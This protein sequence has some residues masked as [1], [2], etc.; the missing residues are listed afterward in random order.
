MAKIFVKV[1]VVMKKSE[2]VK[3]YG[4]GLLGEQFSLSA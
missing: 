1:F 3:S 4:S 2:L